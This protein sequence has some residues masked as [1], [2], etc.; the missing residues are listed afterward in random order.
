MTFDDFF[1]HRGVDYS[2][3]EIKVARSISWEQIEASLPSEVGTLDVRDF[4]EGGVLDYVNNFSKYLIPRELQAI[5]RT[6]R[7]M[8]E[9][10]EWPKVVK[11][12]IA[13]RLCQIIDEAELYHLDN[14][15]LL[16]G[17]FAVSKQEFQGSIEL[18]R[19]IM[20]LKPL[21]SLCRPMEAD[22]CTLPSVTQLGSC[23]LED[24]EVLL[25]SSEDLKCYFYLLGVPQ[26]WVPF[27]GFGG[28]FPLNY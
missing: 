4:C 11:G 19:L 12:L 8:C 28:R 18:C 26:A 9:E 13:T 10:A 22:T 24:G 14:K 3:E 2:G 27:L 7:V 16:N 5:G 20:N 6:P 25:S 21:N 17:M 23:Y 1:V 15:P